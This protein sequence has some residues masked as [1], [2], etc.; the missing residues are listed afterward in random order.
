MVAATMNA[1]EK[2][3]RAADDR[4]C[5]V[6]TQS[7]TCKCFLQKIAGSNSVK[8]TDVIA[9]MRP[10]RSVKK[11]IALA[12][13]NEVAAMVPDRTIHRTAGGAFLKKDDNVVR[14]TVGVC[15]DDDDDSV[16]G[17]TCC[18]CCPRSRSI[19]LQMACELIATKSV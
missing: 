19:L 1:R 17:C 13:V 5:T 8:G 15:I 16:H 3:T 12:T 9:P 2:Y 7:G 4:L 10:T 6:G 11:G 18:C 14:A